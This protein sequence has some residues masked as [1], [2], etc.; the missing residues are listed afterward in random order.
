LVGTR[1]RMSIDQGNL[2]KCP[3]C[4]HRQLTGRDECDSCGIIFSKH[5]SFT[6]IKTIMNGFLTPKE[7][8][9]IRNT[10][11]RLTRVQHDSTSKMELLVHCHKERLLDMAAH[12]LGKNETIKNMTLGNLEAERHYKTNYNFFSFL[13]K[14]LVIIPFIL[15]VLLTAIALMLRTYV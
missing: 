12:H 1:T 3:K 10:Q 7:I 15:L 8:K 6:P 5:M 4:G 2:Q 13:T 9:E 11:E 14:P